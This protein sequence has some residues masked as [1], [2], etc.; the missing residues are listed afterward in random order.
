[1]AKLVLRTLSLHWPERHESARAY[2]LTCIPKPS[3]DRVRKFCRGMSPFAR[4]E[5][6]PILTPALWRTYSV[7]PRGSVVSLIV[8]KGS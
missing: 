8:L 2:R 6:H 1:M 4:S 3:S 5:P 7:P